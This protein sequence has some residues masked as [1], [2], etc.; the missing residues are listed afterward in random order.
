MT[1]PVETFDLNLLVAYARLR[2]HSAI[3]LRA[4]RD[5]AMVRAMAV[6][7][8]RGIGQRARHLAPRILSI[9]IGGMQ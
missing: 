1:Q 3:D 8:N 6:V 4:E 9:L 7:H 2:I 5:F